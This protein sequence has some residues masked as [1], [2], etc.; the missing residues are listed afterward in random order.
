MDGAF[1]CFG[2]HYYLALTG[3]TRLELLTAERRQ[4]LVASR[5]KPESPDTLK[6]V[7]ESFLNN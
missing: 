6:A 3:Q 5:Y 2:V 1:K 4:L 7:V